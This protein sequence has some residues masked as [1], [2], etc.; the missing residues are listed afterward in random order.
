MTIQIDQLILLELSDPIRYPKFFGVVSTY[1]IYGQCGR[2]FS[3]SSCIKDGYC[4]KYY[5]KTFNSTTVIKDSRYSSYRRQDIEVITEKKM[6]NRNV[7][8]YN[9]YLLMSYQPHVNIESCNK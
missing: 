5:P 7:I 4:T 1:M 6:S 8:P 9:T 2:T 3:R